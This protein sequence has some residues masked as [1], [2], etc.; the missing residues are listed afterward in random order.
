MLTNIVHIK[1]HS[2]KLLTARSRNLNKIFAI[3]TIQPRFNCY[4]S[5]ILST[6]G[7]PSDKTEFLQLDRMPV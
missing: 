2:H 3:N 1:E 7:E 5:P 6:K 4:H